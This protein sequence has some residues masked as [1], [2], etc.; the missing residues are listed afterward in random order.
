MNA[1]ITHE[2]RKSS[3]D[4]NSSPGIFPFVSECDNLKQESD[5]KVVQKF[6][7]SGIQQYY[8]KKQDKSVTLEQEKSKVVYVKETEPELIISD[9]VSLMTCKIDLNTAKDDDFDLQTLKGNYIKLN[10]YCFSVKME[11]ILSENKDF[12]KI[13]LVIKKYQL[14]NDSSLKL[15]KNIK[16]QKQVSENPKVEN[17]IKY[18][19]HKLCKNAAATLSP[20]DMT[21]PSISGLINNKGDDFNPVIKIQQK[22]LR[23]SVVKTQGFQNPSQSDIDDIFTSL[24]PLDYSKVCEVVKEKELNEEEK[25]L[26]NSLEK[27]PDGGAL[28]NIL[29]GL[30]ENNYDES[31]EA[32]HSSSSQKGK[33]DM[34]IDQEELEDVIDSDSDC[35]DPP[36]KPKEQ[37]DGYDLDE[38]EDCIDSDPDFN[39]KGEVE[40]P[41]VIPK[42]VLKQREQAL[43]NLSNRVSLHT[44]EKKDKLKK[45]F[46]SNITKKEWD[47]FKQ[48]YQD[49]SSH[50]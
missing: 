14:F 36:A 10:D 33:D 48:W 24:P 25:E 1:R 4:G 19:K 46:T 40:K 34:D 45:D 42:S 47:K 21:M 22:N 28:T 31:E 7:L 27:V 43:K 6:F 18:T 29:V 8:R 38:L 50:N 44:K 9:G 37:V 12:A 11:S 26:M 13:L 20:E 39:P 16:L 2:E 23:K 5:R 41:K 35:A 3:K 32:I 15:T 49:Q 30:Y 17:L